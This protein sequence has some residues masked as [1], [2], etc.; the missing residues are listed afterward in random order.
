MDNVVKNEDILFQEIKSEGNYIT[1]SAYSINYD[2]DFI[3]IFKRNKCISVMEELSFTMV[4]YRFR[5]VSTC[6]VIE[7][8]MKKL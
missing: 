2:G 3:L 5:I 4:E 7:K 6:I 8:M 1:K